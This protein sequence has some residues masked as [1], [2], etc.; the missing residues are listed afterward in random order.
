MPFSHLL[1]WNDIVN[2]KPEPGNEA[3]CL[4]GEPEP[5]PYTNEYEEIRFLRA[6]HTPEDV[7]DSIK[8]GIRNRVAA[9]R[10]TRLGQVPQ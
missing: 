8:Q 3:C 4:P 5:Y 1:S 10:A 6:D 7:I 9:D 2:A